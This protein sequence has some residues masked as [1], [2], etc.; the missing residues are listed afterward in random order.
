MGAVINIMTPTNHHDPGRKNSA[1]V[2]RVRTYDGDRD[3]DAKQRKPHECQPF[4]RLDV[5]SIVVA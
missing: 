1:T 5:C 2:S 4:Q 3:T